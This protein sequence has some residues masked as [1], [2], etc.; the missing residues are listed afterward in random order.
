MA[1]RRQ[2][3]QQPGTGCVTPYAP[4]V[5]CGPPQ[6]SVVLDVVEGAQ[7]TRITVI[8][9]AEPD[10][11]PGLARCQPDARVADWPVAS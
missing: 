7:E 3:Q 2:F 11:N 5:V 4:E 1:R 10:R 6:V 8:E 9:S